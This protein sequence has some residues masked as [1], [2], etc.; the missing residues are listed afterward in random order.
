MRIANEGLVYSP[1]LDAGSSATTDIDFNKNNLQKWT[2]PSSGSLELTASA[3]A[4]G[5]RVK[6]LIDM[7]NTSETEITVPSGWT[8]FGGSQPDLL[9]GAG[10]VLVEL[11]SW[12]TGDSDV[13]AEWDEDT[14]S[15]GGGGGE[16][17]EGP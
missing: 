12:G 11:I 3:H 5:K 13:T 9:N 15:G 17:G 1:V 8:L 14:G 4:A 7:S 6:L 2:C 10:T 16:G